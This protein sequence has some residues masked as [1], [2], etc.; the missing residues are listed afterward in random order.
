MEEIFNNYIE[1]TFGEAKQNEAKFI[2]FE[3]NYRK[4]FPRPENA[5]VLDIGIGRGEMLSCFKRWG[6]TDHLGI[7]I[8]RST[9]EFCNLLGLRCQHV[10]DASQWLELHPTTFDVI[11]LLDVLEHFPKS[12]VVPFLKTIYAAVKPG[13]KI[14]IQVPN[15]QAPDFQLHRYNDFTHEIGFIEHSLAQVLLAAGITNFFF[16]G[17]EWDTSKKINTKI[18]LILRSWHWRYV[19]LIRRIHTNLNPDI[20]HPIFFA[21]VTKES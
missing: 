18:K 21:V 17:F 19:R 8:S 10:P 2:Q 11:T 1:H 20:L 15:A 14:I 12:E 4:F 6:Y 9:I 7:D 13:G 5:K 16:G 3:N